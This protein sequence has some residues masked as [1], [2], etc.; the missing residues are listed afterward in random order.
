MRHT[1]LFF[2]FCSFSYL[3]HAQISIETK[4]DSS[5]ILIG[6][7][8]HLSASISL[9]SN[10]KA[11]FPEYENGYLTDGVEVLERSNI[12]TILLNEG[13]RMQLTRNY[14]LTA[15]DS[16]LYYLPPI[17]I[18]VDE[19]EY[20]SSERLGLKVNTIPIDSIDPNNIFPPHIVVES[21]FK[22]VP[23]LLLISISLW[24][25]LIA[26]TL[27]FCRLSNKKA[28]T[29][30]VILPPPAPPHKLAIEAI[31]KLK[32]NS[33]AQE[34]EKEYYIHLTDI[35]RT[36]IQNRFKI[37][38]LEMTSSEI[39]NMLQEYTPNEIEEIRTVLNTADL[40][41][42]AKY[43]TTLSEN[44]KNLVSIVEFVSSTQQEN[45]E[46]KPIVIEQNVEEKK[47]K[48]IR[49]IQYTATAALSLVIVLTT[50]YLIK[51]ILYTYF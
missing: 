37:N 1:L 47:Q 2:L 41:K 28:M 22:W 3:S 36:Y 29:K 6:E 12:D 24:I 15:F 26:V 25:G 50:I 48:Q 43:Q 13:K 42:F 27:L 46:E 11:I 30:R 18:L 44:D 5:Y 23:R 21:K 34:D 33:K 51:E 7:Q 35:L 10:Q 17:K 31:N 8:V 9:D 32:A 45:P 16:A 14:T 19:K 39:I 38:A 40:V 20:S 49:M 4:L